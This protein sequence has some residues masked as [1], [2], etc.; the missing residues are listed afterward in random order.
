MRNLFFIEKIKKKLE[1]NEFIKNLSIMVLG[2][3]VSQ[4]VPLIFMPI[5]SRVYPVEEHGLY[6]IFFNIL[7]SI[8]IVATLRYELA[9]VIGEDQNEAL[10]IFRVSALSATFMSLLC[11]C[12]FFFFSKTVLSIVGGNQN[13]EIG[14]WIL[15][16]PVGIFFNGLI[17]SY[18]YLLNR[19]KSY[20][21]LTKSKLILASVSVLLPLVLS[22]IVMV[23]GA[24]IISYL[25]SQFLCLLYLCF[26]SKTQSED[27]NQKFVM[28]DL[29]KIFLKYKKFPLLNAPSSIIDQLAAVIPL[30]FINKKFGIENAAYYVMALKVVSIPISLLSYSVSQTLFSEIASRIE[31]K[32]S[33]YFLLKK[34]LINLLIIGVFPTIVLLFFGE[35]L[36]GFVFGSQWTTSGKM[37]MVMS[38][39]TYVK[40]VVSPL[41]ISLIAMK[42]LKTIAFWQVLYLV[43]NLAVIYL[44]PNQTIMQYVF[45]LMISDVIIYVIYVG[46]IFYN[47][48]KTSG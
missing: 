9:I 8:S 41:S 5:L 1:T 35:L 33:F 34:A 3:L 7:V 46:L 16:V 23:K 17:Q 22:M 21:E 47:S 36:F 48:K 25:F 40:F 2:T 38:V 10:K 15:F 11:F 29:K 12:I 45:W 18:S 28:N 19:N 43:F 14:F 31:K 37:V 20:T 4:A 6:G 30:F 13:E 32:E 27:N 24:L 44:L 42:K 39:S 26:S